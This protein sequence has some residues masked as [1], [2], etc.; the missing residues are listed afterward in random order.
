MIQLW[1]R[2]FFRK[3]SFHYVKLCRHFAADKSD[4]LLEEVST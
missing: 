4:K 3:V 2:F 1:T